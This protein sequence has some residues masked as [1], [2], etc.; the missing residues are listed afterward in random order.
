M[1]NRWYQEAVIYCV[2]LD[3]F[4]DG[5]GDG[6]GD[7]LGLTQGLAYLS[8]LGVNCLWL[9]PFY[10]SP[11]KDDGYDITDYLGVN[12]CYGDLGDFALFMG[13]AKDRGIRVLIDLVVN[14][15]SDQ[16]P[17]FQAAR[18]DGPGSK[19]WDYY[20]W[21]DHPPADTSDQVVFPGKQAGVWSYDEVAR[22]SYYHRFY[23]FQP[24][25]NMRNPAVRAEIKKIM[26]F[27]LS[28]GVAGFRMDAVPF[29]IETGLGGN[30]PGPA[31]KHFEYLREFREYLSW[32]TGDAILLAEANVEPKDML[33]YFGED[34]DRLHKLLNFYLNAHLFLAFARGTAEPIRR[35]I[36]ALPCLPPGASWGLF[37]RNHDELDLSGL[38]SDGKEDV[39]ETFAPDKNMRL[40]GRGIRRRLAPML[41]GDQARILLAFS[42]IFSLPGSPLI[43]YGDELGMGE[44]LS[45]EERNTVRTPFQWNTERNADFSRAPA[46]KL[47]R[48]V[49]ADG[50]P[51]DYHRVNAQCQRRHP[52]SLLNGIVRLIRTRKEC[53]QIGAGGFRLVKTDHDETV[54][55]HACTDGDWA[56]LALHNLGAQPL[57]GVRVKIW[58][59]RYDSASL[60]FDEHDNLPIE[61]CELRVDL[62]GYG[63]SWLRL[64]RKDLP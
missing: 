54:F 46:D 19:Y 32:R 12:P 30:D 4:R 39:F 31:E 11:D 26:N 40:Y 27:W 3:V 7:F 55:A 15:T 22:T 37:L 23:D 25:L 59:D 8:G 24:D 29:V 6:K 62:E 2:E 57:P 1:D 16:H 34:G 38:D 10:P 50:G 28:L 44:D 58:D 56:I 63:Y 61:D 43:W 9:L 42:L 45:L 33:P 13:E 47:H 51:F 48:P 5:N 20:V 64:R 49:I 52:A 21:N 60:L 41:G 53:R 14:H 35:A 17:W 36:E 18:R